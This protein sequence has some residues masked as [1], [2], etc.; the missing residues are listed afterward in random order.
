M[1]PQLTLNPL[2]IKD[3]TKALQQFKMPVKRMV[4]NRDDAERRSKEKEKDLEDYVEGIEWNQ[5]RKGFV[6]FLGVLERAKLNF[7]FEG[8]ELVEFVKWFGEGAEIDE[9]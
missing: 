8:E 6:N 1:H 3:V 9:M 4:D 5:G 7:G 2:L